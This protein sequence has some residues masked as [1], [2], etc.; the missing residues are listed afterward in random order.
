MSAGLLALL[1]ETATAT[2]GAMVKTTGVV[3]D[4][5][6]VSCNQF[7]GGQPD[8]K[9]PMVMKVAKRSLINKAILIPSALALSLTFP[10]AILPALAVGGALLCYDSMHKITHKAIKPPPVAVS[11]AYANDHAAWE[12]RHVKSAMHTDLVLSAEVTTVS[13]WSVTGAPVLVQLGTLTATGLAMTA[14]VYTAVAAI[15]KMDDAGVALEKVKG[16]GL[17]A[18]TCHKAGKAIGHVA[19][20][21]IKTIGVVGMAAMFLVGGTMLVHG[22]PGGEHLVGAAVSALGANAVVQAVAVVALQFG[23]GVVA[24]I[25]SLP[26][27]K[28]VIPAYK[29]SVAWTRKLFGK[30]DITKPLAQSPQAPEPAPKLLPPKGSASTALNAAVRLDAPAN[31]TQAKPVLAAKPPKP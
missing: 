10:A 17:F 7:I 25:A 1:Q 9:I 23:V 12:K 15:I 20:K 5:L 27:A 14:A 28:V 31:D 30:P 29:K 11:E 2:Q 6:A 4:D 26:V 16:N 24:G 3:C 13:L 19:P 18:K 21:L 8:R 22:I